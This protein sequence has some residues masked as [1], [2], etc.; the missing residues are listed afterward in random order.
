MKII[1]LKSQNI[2]NIKAIEITPEGNAVILSGRNGAGKSAV[3]DSIMMG[4]TGKKFK[5]P[6]RKSEERAEVFMDLG[7]FR[8]RK[9][10]TQKGERLEV[11][12]SEGAK[13]ASPQTLLN[14]ILGEL[15][16]D[17]LAFKNMKE[18]EQREL[19]IK[20][21]GLDFSESESKH[22][23]LY[24]ERTFKNREVK[25]L[26]AQLGAM[27]KPGEGLPEKEISIGDELSKIDDLEHQKSEHDRFLTAQEN[28]A[29]DI[30]GSKKEILACEEQ[31]Q[32]IQ[33][34]I[35]MFKEHIRFSKKQMEELK[36]PA[37]VADEQIGEAKRAIQQVEDINVKIR[38][39]RRYNNL[40]KQ[41]QEAIRGVEK[42]TGDIGR[43]DK[44]K[45]YKIETC[46]FPVAGLSINEAVVLFEGIPFSQLSTG[47]QVKISTSIAMA[48]SPKLRVILV[49]DGS[50]LD[51]KGLQAIIE[52]AK[53]KDY[54]I[55]IEKCDESGEVGIFIEAGE[56]KKINKN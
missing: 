48:L 16:F 22:K 32:E 43:I 9:T 19:L 37:I 13:Y 3:L 12:N 26:E 4:L 1:Q 51:R 38:T 44:L 41:L 2:K 31:I 11:V 29:A 24:D 46:A 20:V 53:E 17:P 18:R 39:A 49:R 40:A 15:S 27:E 55:W 42:L 14:K 30:E 35:K 47:Q 54:Q 23:G 5:E 45:A 56:I 33:E 36:E 28:L 25:S 10:W 21:V 50:L 6:I 34:R 8:V 7:K 52:Q